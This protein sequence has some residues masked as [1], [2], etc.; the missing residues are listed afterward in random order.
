MEFEWDENKNK[1]NLRKHHLSFE[2][3]IPAFFD[4]HAVYYEDTR[5]AYY[6]QRMVLIGATPEGLVYVAYAEVEDDIIRL[7]SARAVEDID[8]R[9]YRR[10]Y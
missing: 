6:E 8:I 5:F 1:E 4:D 2:D 7:I 9:R 10:G 3:V